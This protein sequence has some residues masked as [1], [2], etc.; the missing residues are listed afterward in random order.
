MDGL[1]LQLIVHSYLY[2]AELFID[3][4]VF[5]SRYKISFD[6]KDD[7]KSSLAFLKEYI[8][9]REKEK[10]KPTAST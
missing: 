5:T 6:E 7:P 2:D 8:N 10:K 3:N 4:R 1:R 9:K